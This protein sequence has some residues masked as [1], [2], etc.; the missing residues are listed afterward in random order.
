MRWVFMALGLLFFVTGVRN[1]RVGDVE[2]QVHR[3]PIPRRMLGFFQ[4]LV[5]LLI[6]GVLLSLFT[7]PKP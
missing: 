7:A 4:I 3:L 5:A 2:P 6:G 1:V